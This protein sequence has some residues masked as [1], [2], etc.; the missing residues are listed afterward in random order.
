MRT[1]LATLLRARRTRRGLPASVRERLQG[2]RRGFAERPALDQPLALARF[3]AFDLE[4]TGANMY[5]DRIISIGAVAVTARTVRHDDAFEAVLRQERSSEVANILVH[6][7]GGQQ[8]LA[9]GDPLEALVSCL[10]FVGESRIVAFRA[11][12]DATVFRR[13]VREVLGLRAWPRF[14]DLAA[15]LPALFPGT[16]NDTLDEWVGHFSLP[17]IGRHHAIADAYANA[18]LMLLVLDAAQRVGVETLRDLRDLERAQ[19]WLGRR[20]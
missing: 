11:E 13:E 14:M 7:I 10:E 5:R 3:V 17:P 6:Q 20:R 8:Q 18:Q 19:R 9:G 16:N 4:T 2:V 1:L 12:F 15:I